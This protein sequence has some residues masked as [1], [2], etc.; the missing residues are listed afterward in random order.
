MSSEPIGT[1]ESIVIS[2]YIKF[3][4]Q[5]KV[6]AFARSDRGG[7]DVMIPR[8]LCVASN[9]GPASKGARVTCRAIVTMNGPRAIE[10]LSIDRTDAVPTVAAERG[11]FVAARVKW[12]NYLKG[13]GFLT[14][15]GHPDIFIHAAVMKK[16]GIRELKPEQAVLV[17]YQ[18]NSNGPTAL[19]L[20][21]GD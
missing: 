20:M 4:D 2:G 11:E 9:I 6:I 19:E 10:V 5:Q 3:F 7:R 13:Y 1:P 21:A 12:F 16:C 15:E 8:D 14:R 18:T 17:R